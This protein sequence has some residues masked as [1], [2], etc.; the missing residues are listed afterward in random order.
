MIARSKGRWWEGNGRRYIMGRRGIKG[1]ESRVG[2]ECSIS[3]GWGQIPQ[4]K[5]TCRRIPRRESQCCG[6]GDSSKSESC[7]ELLIWIKK[8]VSTLDGSIWSK[9]SIALTCP[10]R[11]HFQRTQSRERW[12]QGWN[13]RYRSS[14]KGGE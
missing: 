6:R 2:R 7:Q 4:W 1:L 11:T 10:A 3:R 9:R 13:E 8:V 12:G 14:R 5:Y